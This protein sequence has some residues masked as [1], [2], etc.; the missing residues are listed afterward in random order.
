MYLYEFIVFYFTFRFFKHCYKLETYQ[1]VI[2]R[3]CVE[4]KQYCINNCEV[5]TQVDG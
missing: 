2:G 3:C 4:N 5:T 1:N